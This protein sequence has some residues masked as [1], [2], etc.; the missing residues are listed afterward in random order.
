MG[1]LPF[2]PSK[3][4]AARAAAERE[5]AEKAVLPVPPPTTPAP[6]PAGGGGGALSVSA[7]ASLI[8]ST[9]RDSLPKKIRVVGEISNFKVQTHWYFNLKDAASVIS[10]VMWSSLTARAALDNYT[11][12]NG[13]QVVL[14][15]RVE[16]WPKG[17]RTQFYVERIEPVGAGAL[18]LA[19]KK[20]YEELRALGWFAPERKKPIPRFPRR[21]A[22]VTSRTGAALQ[23]VLNTMQR[24]APS[25]A[26]ALVDVRVQGDGAAAEIVRAL[27]WL[28]RVH[29][30]EQIDAVILTRGGGS[31]E[32]LWTFNER[33]VAK[34]ILDCPLPIVAAIGHEVDVTI[35]ELVADERCATPTQAAMR[36]TPDSAALEEQLDGLQRRLTSLVITRCRHERERLRSAARHPFFTDPSARLLDAAADLADLS[37][38]FAASARQR[39]AS[40]AARLD[41]ADARLALHRPAAAYARRQADLGRLSALLHS[42][43][44]ARLRRA[45]DSL[46]APNHLQSAFAASAD[47]TLLELDAAERALELVGPISVLRRGFSCTLRED[48][49]AVRSIHDVTVGQPLQTRVADGTFRTIVAREGTNEGA[50]PT[51]SPRTTTA[52]P[53]RRRRARRPD[54]ADDQPTLFPGIPPSGP[55]PGTGG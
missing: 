11:P 28:A 24:R 14:T 33:S 49:S 5:R 38:R 35:A 44:D 50:L 12:E 46:P 17:G 25:V 41:R 34:A 45:A 22:V 10:C 2:D 48:G 40:L 3:M 21:I 1:R 53:A 8:E 36:L 32:D 26:V 19:F 30:R 54:D 39:A 23:D 37:R 13:Q 27:G 43:I 29:A 51:P 42:A 20:L 16:F 47:R 6:S 55:G 52:P 18:D 15:G 31:K 4:A 7:L 9:L